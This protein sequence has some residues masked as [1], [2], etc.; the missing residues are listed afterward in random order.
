MQKNDIAVYIPDAEATKWLLFQQH[1]EI[2]AIL[3]E[4]GVFN[5]RN[6]SV[7]LHF[8]PQGVLQAVNRADFLYS[9]KHGYP[10]QTSVP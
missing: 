2:F 7:A 10:Q 4:S 1:Y 3:L 6:G 9:K 5:V 8:D